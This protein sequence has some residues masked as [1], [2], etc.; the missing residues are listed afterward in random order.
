MLERG[1]N[2]TFRDSS[3]FKPADDR[4]YNDYTPTEEAIQ[5]NRAR[6][7]ERTK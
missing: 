6:I 7:K 4:F 3:I 5:I 2:P 1:Y